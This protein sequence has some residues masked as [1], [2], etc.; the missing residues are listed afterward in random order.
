MHAPNHLALL[1]ASAMISGAYAQTETPPS[2]PSE[3]AGSTGVQ[4]VTV[5]AQKRLQL[6]QEVPLA[7][8]A[9]GS[10]YIAK[11]GAA[12]LKDVVSAIPSLQFTQSQSA[13][14]SSVTIRGVGSSGGVAGLEPSVGM[15]IDGIYLD[16]TYMGLGDFNDI[17]RIEVLRGPQGTLFGKNTPAGVI[18]FITKRPAFKFGGAAEATVGN[19]GLRKVAATVTTPLI[20]ETL[21]W[22]VSAFDSQRDGY[23]HNTW[24]DQAVNDSQSRGLRARALWRATED[25]ELLLSY[26]RTTQKGLCCAAETGPVAAPRLASAAAAGRPFPT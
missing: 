8:S 3:P 26:E 14:Q 15:Y 13:V 1:I 6:A 23:L 4:S 11:S 19:Y 10:E 20:S 5:T 2:P 17:E 16:R 24:T 22:R 12:S 21:A 25:V 18:N 7:V 9:V